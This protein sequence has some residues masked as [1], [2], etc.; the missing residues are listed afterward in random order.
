MSGNSTEKAEHLYNGDRRLDSLEEA[1]EDLIYERV[2]GLDVPVV[3]VM[4]ILERLKIKFNDSL[5]ET[6][7]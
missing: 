6:Q 1:I 5:N 3:A 4:G 2:G 7:E